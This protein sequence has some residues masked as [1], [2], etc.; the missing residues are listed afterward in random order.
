MM[1]VGR[2]YSSLEKYK[3]D[4][5]YLDRDK[6]LNVD[7]V[8]M[9]GS[10]WQY[11]NIDINNKLDSNGEL[12]NRDFTN[13]SKGKDLEGNLLSK[14]FAGKHRGGYDMVWAP[15]KSVTML[16]FQSKENLEKVSNIMM[17]VAKDTVAFAEKQGFIQYRQNID[18]EVVSKTADNATALINLHLTGRQD[19]QIHAHM[20][21]FNFARDDDGKYRALNSDSLF[22][23]RFTMEA[24]AENNLAHRIQKEFSQQIDFVKTGNSR[25]YT[26]KV[27]GLDE[28]VWG[29]IA[30]TGKA[31]DEYYDKHKDKLTAKYPEAS[32]AQIKEK[33]YL[34]IRNSK[35]SK[36]LDEVFKQVDEGLSEAGLTRDDVADI[37]AKNEIDNSIQNKLSADEIANYAITELENRKSSFTT[38]ELNKTALQLSGGLYNSDDILKAVDRAKNRLVSLDKYQI[39]T[40]RTSYESEIITTKDIITAQNSIVRTVEQGRDAVEAINKADYHND[41]LTGAQNNTI[42]F[43]LKSQDRVI[44]VNGWAGTGKTTFLTELKKEV[45][46]AGYK[47][48]VGTSTTNTAVNEM[49]AKEIDAITTTK[50]NMDGDNKLND[51]SILV[52]D[53]SS[54]LSTKELD[55]VL[56]KV[57]ESGARAILIGDTHQLTGVGAGSPFALL[58]K[59][60]IVK[61]VEL[62]DIVRQKNETLKSGVYDLYKDDIKSAFDKIEVV[63]IKDKDEAI[64]TIS[65]DYINKGYKDT[66][67]TTSTN[68]DKDL[69]N[70][71]VRDNLFKGRE[72]LE[73]TV[74]DRK[75]IN[76][77]DKYKGDSYAVGDRVSMLNDGRSGDITEVKGN[78]ITIKLD[79]KSLKN[80]DVSRQANNISVYEKKNIKITAGDKIITTGNIQAGNWDRVSNSSVGYVASIDT[81]NKSFTLEIDNKRI[82]S[83]AIDKNTNYFTY[84]YALTAD[85]SQGKTVKNVITYETRNFENTLVSNTRATDSATVYTSD[86]ENYMQRS[87]IKSVDIRVD[88][89]QYQKTKDMDFSKYPDTGRFQ[90]SF[91]DIDDLADYLS[92]D[93]TEANINKIQGIDEAKTNDNKIQDTKGIDEAKTKLTNAEQNKGLPATEISK[94]DGKQE[95]KTMAEADTFSFGRAINGYIISLERKQDGKVI[96]T[97]EMSI[98]EIKRE[99]FRYKEKYGNFK[100]IKEAFKSFDKFIEKRD[101][102]SFRDFQKKVKDLEVLSKK[103]DKQNAEFNKIKAEP[104]WHVKDG[105][106]VLSQLN[107]EKR[108][109][110]DIIVRDID[111]QVSSK[112]VASFTSDLANATTVEKGS[113]P[114]KDISR[115]TETTYSITLANKVNVVSATREG[116]T[117]RLDRT[118][119][120]KSPDGEYRQ[121]E[122]ADSYKINIKEIKKELSQCKE[123]YGDLNEIKQTEQAL[124]KLVKKLDG[125]SFLNLQEKSKALD[126]KIRNER[127]KELDKAI[128]KTINKE[129]EKVAELSR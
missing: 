37:L 122:N 61:S 45:E 75:A 67:I 2:V 55:K 81:I 87:G 41:K 108:Q 40:A 26:T 113:N 121:T 86:K 56:Q 54:F 19:P 71:E 88:E 89:M 3:Q 97:K 43:I 11:A 10:G 14:S 78:I 51:R 77:I 46:K 27:K 57:N 4:N 79:D 42:N 17:E 47:N 23:N 35:Q 32:E 106:M 7:T 80:I 107:T 92:S 28:T 49:R 101:T 74:Y 58:V 9:A 120:V 103:I 84:G 6:S 110:E 104:F 126:D 116:D 93:K 128:D 48:I 59:N 63:E 15:D 105:K 18:G 119:Y 123:M 62:D 50:L 29:G 30:R 100:E 91:K 12:T 127:L 98:I 8:Q 34:K 96:E 125:N 112:L 111:K 13:L 69:I 64:K 1:T 31:I 53:E 129:A 73:V 22:M 38:A 109:Y 60:N 65:E 52:L 115:K 5:Y 44:A 70:Q 76:G 94:A 72:S 25:E 85:R 21:F 66:L 82:P 68:D 24:Y 102:N 83:H 16:A 117:I 95:A 124:N 20:A 118:E 114:D 39:K 33:V 90:P 36:T 99:L